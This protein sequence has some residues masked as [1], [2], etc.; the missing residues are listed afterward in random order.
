M[1]ICKL[2]KILAKVNTF[3]VELSLWD[4]HFNHFFF[5]DSHKLST[6]D[7]DNWSILS[8]NGLYLFIKLSGQSRSGIRQSVNH[9]VTPMNN[10]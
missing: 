5:F 6:L 10:V 9:M 1:E 2:H 3:V 8:T 4:S 7:Y